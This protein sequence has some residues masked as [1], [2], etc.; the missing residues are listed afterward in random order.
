MSG[1]QVTQVEKFTS[2]HT[3][4]KKNMALQV[5]EQAPQFTLKTKGPEDL[6]D[7]SLADNLGK[8]QTV[9]LF[10]PLAFTEVCTEEMCTVSGGLSD[11][12]ALDASV[13]GISVDSPFA[14]EGWAKAN[15]ITIPLLSDFNKEVSAQYDVLYAD[16]IGFKGVSKRSAFV[17]GKDGTINYSWSSDDPHNLPPFDEIKAAL[18]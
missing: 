16:L 13:Y 3:Q 6:V 8:K 11:Y 18:Q 5:G 9:L 7:V 14:Q 15:E 1:V 12:E 10:F 2:L 17:I 4:E